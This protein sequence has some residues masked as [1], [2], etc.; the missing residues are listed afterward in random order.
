MARATSVTFLRRCSSMDTRLSALTTYQAS[1]ARAQIHCNRS[2]VSAAP[3]P[4][5]RQAGRTVT[6]AR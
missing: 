2:S 5:L 3:T 1:D 6:P 4:R